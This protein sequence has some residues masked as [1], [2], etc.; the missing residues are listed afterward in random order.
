M[1]ADYEHI[2]ESARK[3]FV[4]EDKGWTG[5]RYFALGAITL[6]ICV[7]TIYMMSTMSG[8]SLQIVR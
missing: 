5:P 7:T 6:I 3:R 4:E 8:C 2:E 1:A